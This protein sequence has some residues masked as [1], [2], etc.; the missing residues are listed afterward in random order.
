[1]RVGNTLI[2]QLAV[3]DRRPETVFF[4]DHIPVVMMSVV[5]GSMMVVVPVIS[6]LD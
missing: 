6:T 3:T 4:C 1:M 5:L 2:Y